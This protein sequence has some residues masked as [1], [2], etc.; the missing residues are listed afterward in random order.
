[1]Q[2]H[3]QFTGANITESAPIYLTATAGQIS[4]TAN[5]TAIAT[6]W[7]NAALSFNI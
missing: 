5:G 6:G 4:T 1:M 7:A 3:T 2:Y